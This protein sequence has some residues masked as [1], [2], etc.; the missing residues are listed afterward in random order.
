MRET[1]GIVLD[2]GHDPDLRDPALGPRL[3]T[4]QR[5]NRKDP[6]PDL[7]VDLDPEAEVDRRRAKRADLAP[8]IKGPRADL[9]VE[10]SLERK[11]EERG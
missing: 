11:M 4:R 1:G 9:E 5:G 10:A 2:P 7:G 8:R 3:P 6:G